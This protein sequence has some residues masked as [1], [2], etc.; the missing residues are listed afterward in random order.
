MSTLL[1]S[2]PAFQ[3][4]LANMPYFDIFYFK[5]YKLESS[6]LTIRVLLVQIDENLK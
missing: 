2:I 4:A 1:E 5:S 6:Y 3:V